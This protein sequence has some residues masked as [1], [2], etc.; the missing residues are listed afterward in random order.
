MNIKKNSTQSN[1]DSALSKLGV[2][3]RFG[4]GIDIKTKSQR[5]FKRV[6]CNSTV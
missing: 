2:S 4:Q 3:V 6:N 1:L 5:N